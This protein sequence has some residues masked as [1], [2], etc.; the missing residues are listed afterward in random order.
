MRRRALLVTALLLSAVIAEGA[1]A[2]RIG[3]EE[4]VT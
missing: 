3:M 1:V 4:D 2:A